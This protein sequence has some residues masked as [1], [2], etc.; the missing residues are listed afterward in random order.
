MPADEEK[1]REWPGP[2]EDWP[3][4]YVDQETFE[5]IERMVKNPRPPTEALVGLFRR[6]KA[7]A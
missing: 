6:T 1:K 7:E 3:V 2:V 5:K 4:T